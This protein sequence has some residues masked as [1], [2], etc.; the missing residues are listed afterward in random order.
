MEYCFYQVVGEYDYS[1]GLGVWAQL[2]RRRSKGQCDLFKISIPCFSIRQ[3][4]T[5][6]VHRSLLLIGAFVFYK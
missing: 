2:L 6:E 5:H 4:F 1:V 3:P